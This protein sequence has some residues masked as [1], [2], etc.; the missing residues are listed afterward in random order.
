MLSQGLVMPAQH[1]AIRQKKRKGQRVEAAAAISA[2][3]NEAEETGA[4]VGVFAASKASAAKFDT[5]ARSAIAAKSAKA[6]RSDAAA[7]A[8]A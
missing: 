4:K 6:A 2:P 1:T 5:T 8:P 7:A 3:R